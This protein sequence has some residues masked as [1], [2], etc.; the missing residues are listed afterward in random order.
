MGRRV[1]GVEA[2]GA[3]SGAQGSATQRR[4]RD[5][6]DR[7]KG[8]TFADGRFKLNTCERIQNEDT[9]ALKGISCA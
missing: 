4:E 1:E 3:N 8:S 9:V 5:W 7:W 6:T 2:K